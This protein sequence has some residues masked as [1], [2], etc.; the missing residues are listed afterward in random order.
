MKHS[1]MNEA[2]GH[3]HQAQ[4]HLCHFQN[5]LKDLDKQFDIH[6]ETGNLLTFADFFFDGLIVDWIVQGRISQSFDQV[7]KVDGK[8]KDLL[9]SL[10][11]ER[12][13]VLEQLDRVAQERRIFVEQAR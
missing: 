2:G 3:I 6:L 4:R 13:A 10:R 9:G 5:E 7:E 11:K 12:Q 1:H 8:V